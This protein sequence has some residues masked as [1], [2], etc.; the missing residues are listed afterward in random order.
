M[1]RTIPE[2]PILTSRDTVGYFK[3]EKTRVRIATNPDVYISKKA[4]DEANGK[5]HDMDY[6]SPKDQKKKIDASW[7]KFKKA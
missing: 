1:A 5:F 4:F 6:V 7:R 2:T 3:T